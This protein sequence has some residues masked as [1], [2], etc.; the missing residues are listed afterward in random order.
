MSLTMPQ[1]TEY[2]I[3]A[4]AVV[5]L[6]V[7]GLLIARRLRS[8]ALERRFGSEYE[9]TL[10]I[11]GSRG[12]TD[13]ELRRRET[14]VREMQLT[15]L[16]NSQKFRYVA[17]W[18]TVQGNFVDEPREAVER[19]ELLVTSVMR[20]RGYKSENFDERVE[21]LSPDHPH[22]VEH[23]REA[24]EIV[25]RARTDGTTTEDLRRAIID[26]RTIFDELVGQPRARVH[27]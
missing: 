5:V 27:S 23:L 18:R 4:G 19:A 2:A 14:R 22:V 8:E 16:P 15:E 13:A 9:R 17:Q 1:T 21:D 20:D 10:N 12:R 7:L 26:Y 11:T 25:K 24:H 3:V 6:V